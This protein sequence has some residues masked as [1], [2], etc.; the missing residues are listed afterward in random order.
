MRRR[1][2][3]FLAAV[4]AAISGA[5]VSIAG[6]ALPITTAPVISGSSSTRP[7]PLAVM[8]TPFKS[9][10]D[11]NNSDWISQA[12]EEELASDLNRNASVRVMHSPT[13]GPSSDGLNEARQA[14]AQ[15]LIVGTYQ[16]VDDQVRINGEVVDPTDGKSVGHLR[17][18]GAKRD[19]FKLEDSLAAELLHVLPSADEPDQA[20]TVTPVESAGMSSQAGT[21]QPIIIQSGPSDAAAGDPYAGASYPTNPDI[22]YGGYGDYPG[23]GYGYGYPYFDSPFFIYFRGGNRFG[24]R[25]GNFGNNGF[26]HFHGGLTGGGPIVPTERVPTDRVQTFPNGTVSGPGPASVTPS[27]GFVG[28][29]GPSAAGHGGGSGFGGWRRQALKDR[30]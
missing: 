23:Y 14:G 22:N 7:A 3:S 6:S 29:T 8:L 4:V 26:N 21:P 17:V 20:F 5:A 16:A 15:R 18:T 9:I 24:N 1:I 28:P 13:T 25:G 19:L 10:G 11:S 2:I 12:I 30:N 27:H